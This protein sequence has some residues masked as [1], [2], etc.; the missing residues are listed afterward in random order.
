MPAMKPPPVIPGG[1]A[2]GSPFEALL[3]EDRLAQL[4]RMSPDRKREVYGRV[5]DSVFS[6]PAYRDLVS[7]A[8]ER[9][10]DLM[11]GTGGASRDAIADTV[12]NVLRSRG[13]A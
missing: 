1:L 8:A 9:E 2:A 5:V 13:L 6:D 12:V 4:Q 7:S 10:Y 11:T 3:P